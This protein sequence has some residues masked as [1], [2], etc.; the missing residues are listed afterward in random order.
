[1]I[2]GG[3][4]LGPLLPSTINFVKLGSCFKSAIV[5][6]SD[7]DSSLE[8]FYCTP[9]RQILLQPVMCN[10][11]GAV[12]NARQKPNIHG[13]PVE[14]VSRRRDVLLALTG[15]RLLLGKAG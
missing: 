2:S 14:D 15:R 8:I 1:M 5:T 3:L 10:G 6:S 13:E 12:P 9:T 4:N 11:S 7:V